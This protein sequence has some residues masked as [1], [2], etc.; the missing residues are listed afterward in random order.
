MNEFT[1]PHKNKTTVGMVADMLRDRIMN[2]HYRD[3]EFLKQDVLAGEFGVSKIPVREAL[4]VL[5]SEGLITF[6]PNRGAAV[7]T[8]SPQEAREIYIM[9]GALE[10]AVMRFAVPGHTEDDMIKIEYI[11]AR[12][13]REIDAIEWGKLNMEFH[14]ALSAP[15]R[16]P[17]IQEQIMLLNRKVV[18][19]FPVYYDNREKMS[20]VEE[21]DR[22]IAAYKKKDTV[23][24]VS[25]LEQHF[26]KSLD[27]LLEFLEK[28]S[29]A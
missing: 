10:S 15:A 20:S 22:I 24:A 17:Y 19:Y 9:R 12:I 2:R 14:M 27:N 21:H 1:K 8:L 5:E 25:I 23:L 6:F 29:K 16:M 28:D 3:G 18:K 13:K 11:Q 4:I 26:K 7:A